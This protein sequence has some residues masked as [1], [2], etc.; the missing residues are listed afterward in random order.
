MP[1]S[2]SL[3]EEVILDHNKHP[4]N[5]GVL[6]PC[7]RKMEGF[8]PLCGD[9]FTVYLRMDGDVIQEVTF[10]GAGCA[11]SKSSASVMTMLVK[12]KTTQ[13]ATALFKKFHCM[14]TSLPDA[15]LDEDDLGKLRVFSGIREFPVRIKCAT[16]AWHTLAS[17]LNGKDE[18]VSTE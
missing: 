11:I 10:D 18:A 1:E 14:V 6:D 4:R 5:F 8:N 16:L 3:Y 9:H 15:P 17:A 13:E 2:R 7:D 12:G